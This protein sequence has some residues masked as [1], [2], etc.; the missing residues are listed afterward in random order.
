VLVQFADPEPSVPPFE[1]ADNIRV[2][3]T[4][5]SDGHVATGSVQV[6]NPPE[7]ALRENVDWVLRIAPT[8]QDEPGTIKNRPVA[9]KM[10]RTFR[11]SRR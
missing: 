3:F 7:T 10:A 9:V 5:Q 1:T 2:M 8:C 6:V 4:V 11:L